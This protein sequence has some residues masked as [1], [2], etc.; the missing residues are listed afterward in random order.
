M[1]FWIEGREAGSREERGKR[2]PERHK[3]SM[4]DAIEK[5]TV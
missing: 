3:L 2:G 4:C 1:T 5:G